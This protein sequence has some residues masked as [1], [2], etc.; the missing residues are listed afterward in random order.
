MCVPESRRCRVV[1]SIASS[2]G[3]GLLFCQLPRLTL[4]RALFAGFFAGIA[5]LRFREM[6]EADP[7]CSAVL[8]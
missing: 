2:F 3:C 8:V 1:A 4:I 5:L 6:V 7:R